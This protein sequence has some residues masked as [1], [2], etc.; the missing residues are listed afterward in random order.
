MYN[1]EKNN[2]ASPRP[3]WEVAN[4]DDFELNQLIYEKEIVRFIKSR[5][6]T[7]LGRVKRMPGHRTIWRILEWR[8]VGRR[9]RGKQRKCCLD[10]VKRL[11]IHGWRR[12]G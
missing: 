1:S 3:K 5:R 8:L 11:G 12:M 2:R 4:S 6:L 10:A 7:W 9:V